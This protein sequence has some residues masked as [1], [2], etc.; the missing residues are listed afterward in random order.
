MTGRDLKAR[1]PR[2]WEA[3]R[4]PAGGVASGRE[5]RL[6]WPPAPLPR[7]DK[8]SK[9]AAW[10][11][12]FHP[13][14]AC[15]WHFKRES[16]EASGRST[17]LKYLGVGGLLLQF[18]D[19]LVSAYPSAGLHTPA[20]SQSRCDFPLASV[21]AGWSGWRTEA[22]PGKQ[23]WKHLEIRESPSLSVQVEPSIGE[24]ALEVSGRQPDAHCQDSGRTRFELSPTHPRP[25]RV[26]PLSLGFPSGR[27]DPRTLF[28]G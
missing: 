28:W 14:L 18:P 22:E 24:G 7:R 25:D 20:A 5:C 23:T 3:M 8:G 1:R 9:G 19:H 26:I 4:R 6:P 10:R 15:P 27:G 12:G 2:P 16:G 13:W 21:R 11:A 17:S